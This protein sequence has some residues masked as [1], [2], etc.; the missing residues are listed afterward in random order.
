MWSRHFTKPPSSIHC[1]LISEFHLADLFCPHLGL[2]FLMP[3]RPLHNPPDLIVIGSGDIA[4]HSLFN[5]P[6]VID[7]L[8][9][10]A[11]EHIFKVVKH[12]PFRPSP[13]FARRRHWAAQH[14]V[15]V[16]QNVAHQTAFVNS[17]L[18]TSK[19]KGDVSPIWLPRRHSESSLA[20][21]VHDADFAHKK[22]ALK[23]A[24]TSA[25]VRY[26]GSRIP[27]EVSTFSS[28]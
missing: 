7:K 4:T 6:K 18:R 12:N 10:L 14:N 22:G 16:L 25:K 3:L 13:L 5:C 26:F 27:A 8:R 28:A 9:H 2:L 20:F 17:G 19:V 21:E 23:C 1:L 24:V 11:A 15:T